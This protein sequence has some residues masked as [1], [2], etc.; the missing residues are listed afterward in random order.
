MTSVGNTTAE[1]KFVVQP[2]ACFA[3]LASPVGAVLRGRPLMRKRFLEGGAA[4]EDRPYRTSEDRKARR[5]Y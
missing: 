2:F 3:A 5:G 1:T 4:T